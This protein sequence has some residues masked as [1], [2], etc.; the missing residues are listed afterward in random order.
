MYKLFDDSIVDFIDFALLCIIGCNQFVGFL[1]REIVIG[2][3]ED[4]E[5]LTTG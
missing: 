4:G 1:G 3:G 5:H 2:R